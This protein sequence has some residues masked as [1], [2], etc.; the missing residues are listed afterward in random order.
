MIKMKLTEFLQSIK[1]EKVLLEDGKFA[2]AKL[3]KK[4]A[5]KLQKW[6][7]ENDIGNPIPSSEFHVTILY[8][9]KV[10]FPWDAKKYP[11]GLKV[12][13]HTYELALFGEEKNILVLKFDSPEL[14]A[15]HHKAR[16][17]HGVDWKF[18]EYQPH[19]TLSYKVKDLDLSDLEPPGFPLYFSHE[20]YKDNDEEYVKKLKNNV[21]EA[22]VAKVQTMQGDETAVHVNPTYSR[23]FSLLYR[24]ERNRVRGVV[25][26]HGGEERF[27]VWDAADM[28]HHYASHQLNLVSQI[29]LLLDLLL[30]H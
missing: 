14:A 27:L 25:T 20:Y 5:R 9:D 6:I 23:M 26:R 29:L 7:E 2:G 24:S 28:T 22:R 10:D 21:T 19:V 8:S 3:T 13:P 18:D 30:E 4:S 1:T 17:E 15:R 16:D 11:G 12:D